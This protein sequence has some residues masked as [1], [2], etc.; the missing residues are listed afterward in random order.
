MIGETSGIEKPMIAEEALATEY[1]IVKFGTTDEKLKKG[2]AATDKLIGVA[3]GKAK[4]NEKVNVMF[5]GITLVKAGAA[6]TRGDMLTSDASGE[7]TPTT[8]AKNIVV[9]MALAS[10][11]DG[12][13][14]PMVLAQHVL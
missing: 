10:A 14:I 13:V 1:L 11:A 6:I 2:A 12:D 9:G 3:Q 4:A 8:T 7:A 5:T